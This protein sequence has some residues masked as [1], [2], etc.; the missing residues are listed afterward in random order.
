MAEYDYDLFISHASEDK[1]GFV[2]ELVE[3]LRERG[4]RRRVE[5]NIAVLGGRATIEL[6]GWLG[7]SGMAEFRTWNMR[8]H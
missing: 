8:R 4:H 6:T 3:D 1:A 5:L 2:R 7:S